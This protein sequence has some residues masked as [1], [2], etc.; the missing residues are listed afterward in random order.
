MAE[1]PLTPAEEQA[2]EMA[3]RGYIHV[4]DE[5]YPDHRLSSSNRQIFNEL[6]RAFDSGGY[7]MDW[8]I[9]YE[10]D[11]STPKEGFIRIYHN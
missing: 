6:L 7:L 3:S 4:C 5:D 1:N 8:G 11:G 2:R 9:A 10:S